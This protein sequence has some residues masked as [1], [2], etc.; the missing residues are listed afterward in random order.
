MLIAEIKKRFRSGPYDLDFAHQELENLTK[1]LNNEL[2][3]SLALSESSP[4]K[5]YLPPSKQYDLLSKE[6]QEYMAR[7]NIS[8]MSYIRAKISDLFK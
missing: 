7:G 8:A 5:C 2:G 4:I 6:S 3:Q 1:L